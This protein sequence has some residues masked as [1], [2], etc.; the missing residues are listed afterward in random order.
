[1]FA[2][3]SSPLPDFQLLR[4]L[5]ERPYGASIKQLTKDLR[6]VFEAPAVQRVRAMHQEGWLATPNAHGQAVVADPDADVRRLSWVINLN[7]PGIEAMLELL[8]V[9]YG[10][11]V[12]AYRKHFESPLL[13]HLWH[14]QNRA[15]QID[16][17]G[18]TDVERVQQMLTDD[19]PIDA[20]DYRGLLRQAHEIWGLPKHIEQMAQAM[21]HDGP[22]DHNERYRDLVHGM[23]GFMRRM[24]RQP[25]SPGP[26][27]DARPHLVVLAHRA[28]RLAGILDG[29]AEFLATSDAVGQ[30]QAYHAERIA[31]WVQ[32]ERTQPERRWVSAPSLEQHLEGLAE[33]QQRRSGYM[34]N[35]GTPQPYQLGT[36]GEGLLAHMFRTKADSARELV[37]TITAMP[38]LRAVITAT[39]PAFNDTGDGDTGDSA[40]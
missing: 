28:R 26:G 34:P 5:I 13:R 14:V 1:M 39:E 2:Q 31:V 40:A 9:E 6:T 37:E 33:A 10:A 23:L 16:E 21:Y 38:G 35:G 4:A 15:S 19:D 22:L 11:D 8:H 32:E 17:E 7:R 24:P 12:E 30:Q 29:T 27:E 20:R 18:P 36:A 25:A 3:P